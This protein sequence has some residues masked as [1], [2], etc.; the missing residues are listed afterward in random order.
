MPRWPM[1]EMPTQ[2]GERVDTVDV[3]IVGAGFAGMY[4]IVRCVSSGCPCRRSRWPPTSAA[5]G[6]GTAIPARAATS[7]AWNTPTR[8]PT[9]C[10]RNGSGPRS[11]PPSRRFSATSTMSPTGSTCAGASSSRREWSRRCSTSRRT[12]GRSTTDRGDRSPPSSASWP[13]D[14]VGGEHA[15]LEGLETF[16]GDRYHTGHWPHEGVDFSGRRVG[17]IGTGSSAI[18]CIPIIA[19]QAAR[20]TVFQRTPNF[21]LPARNAALDPA[22]Y[23]AM[24]ADY[25]EYRRRARESPTGMPGRTAGEAHV[26]GRRAGAAGGLRSR[27]AERPVRSIAACLHR[28]AH[29]QGGE[30]HGR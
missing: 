2:N 6:S 1:I 13:P 28:S 29:E 15:R 8:S 26:R 17:V 24:K 23:A 16:R 9:S 22:I 21:S 5:P 7:R 14:P 4:M 20:L 25:A 30:R 11:T 18:Q 27:L 10:S 3:V 19:A 12:A